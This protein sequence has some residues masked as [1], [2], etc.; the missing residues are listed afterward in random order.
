MTGVQTCALPIFLRDD[1]TPLKEGDRLVQLDLA[2][3]ISQIRTKGP[4]VF[5]GGDL[6]RTLS[7]GIIEAG[8]GLTV[9][10]LRDYRP[11]WRETVE[12]PFGDHV[13]HSVPPPMSG[14][15]TTLE[16]FAM[17]SRDGRY[18]KTPPEDRPHLFA[19]VALRAF[20][21]RR[22]WLD[23]LGAL[24][25]ASGPLAEAWTERLMA[26]YVAERHTPAKTLSP[27]PRLHREAP[28]GMTFP[29]VHEIGRAHV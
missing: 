8:G 7:R 9:E 24:D 29:V 28:A 23:R 10:N 22:S 27:A 26:N 6:A 25:P 5:Y 21:D 12:L 1:G 2:S 16:Q 13:I 17:L 4:G 14:G 15:I 19:E 18:A 20:A 11:V 3:V